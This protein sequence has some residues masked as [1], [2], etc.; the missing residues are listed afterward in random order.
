[1]AAFSTIIAGLALATTAGGAI[2]SIA[3]KPKAPSLPS[4]P[5][6]P[7][8]AAESADAAERQRRKIASAS[9]RSDT[10]KTN[11]LGSVGADTGAQRKN[12]LGL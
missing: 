3:N 6:E 7:D 1:M 10:I 5:T 12:L 9:G 4:L 2:A 11:P 8:K